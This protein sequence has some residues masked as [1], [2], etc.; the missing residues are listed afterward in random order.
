MAFQYP[1]LKQ[2]LGSMIRNFFS[3]VCRPPF[4][5]ERELFKTEKSLFVVTK[6][7]KGLSSLKEISDSF[8]MAVLLDESKACVFDKKENRWRYLNNCD[9]KDILLPREFKVLSEI[10]ESAKFVVFEI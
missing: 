5:K 3:Y 8:Y 9:L 1:A 2:V 6:S 4:N 7:R 10:I